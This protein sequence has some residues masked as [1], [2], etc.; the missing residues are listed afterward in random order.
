MAVFVYDLLISKTDLPL[1]VTAPAYERI[2]K[3]TSSLYWSPQKF[4][5][6]ITS[7]SI[8]NIYY[9]SFIYRRIL[10]DPW[11]VLWYSINSNEKTYF[12]FSMNTPNSKKEEKRYFQLSPDTVPLL[13]ETV[14][15]NGNSIS[16]SV[17]RALA[18]DVSYRCRELANVS[19]F[20]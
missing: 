2:G 15:I 20:I 16:P 19:F 13:A 9:P 11:L 7:N 8:I 6:W 17:S 12:S 14:G 3:C 5:E 10:K 1:S 18:E 4:K